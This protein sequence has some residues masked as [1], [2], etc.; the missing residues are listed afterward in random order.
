MKTY[1]V[2]DS[3]RRY[4]KGVFMNEKHAFTF[5]EENKDRG[6]FFQAHEATPDPDVWE[7]VRRIA[8][9]NDLTTEKFINL[10]DELFDY[11]NLKGV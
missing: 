4:V 11:F 6:Y 10:Y 5:C 2:F 3:P 7:K 9:K 1:I 8:F